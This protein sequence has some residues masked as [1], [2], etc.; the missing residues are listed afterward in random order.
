[1]TGGDGM[2]LVAA[3]RR[4]VDEQRW[5]PP[6]VPGHA[7]VKR[8]PGRRRVPLPWPGPNGVPDA[9]GGLGQVGRA[10]LG[11]AA[12][13]FRFLAST[14][15]ARGAGPVAV[16]DFRDL[17]RG[18]PSGGAYHPGELYLRW[19][20]SADLPA[21]VYHHDPLHHALTEVA[22][23]ELPAPASYLLACRVWKN[24]QK[25]G[26][27]GYR[28]GCIDLGALA[29]HLLATA[30]GSAISFFFDQEEAD[31][32]AALAPE[33]ETVYALVGPPGRQPA[34]RC[35]DAAGG[36]GPSLDRTL[37]ARV[38]AQTRALHAAAG[39]PP[40][41]VSAPVAPPAPADRMDPGI[42]LSRRSA[43]AF[44]PGGL[45]AERLMDVLAR[46][47]T[48]V[49]SDVPAAVAESGRLSLYCV[50]VGVAGLAPGAYRYD[51][52]RHRLSRCGPGDA[53][54][55]LPAAVFG[56]V[57]PSL[58]GAAS[59]FV[60]GRYESGVRVTGARW[61]RVLNMLAGVVVHRLYLS[62][63]VAGLGARACLGYYVGAVD[64]MLGL[65]GGDTALVHVA[66]GRPAPWP[67][68]VELALF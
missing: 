9:G 43:A 59:V 27:F 2:A 58:L 15:L 68:Q 1:M 12:V 26:D 56:L 4:L 60:V 34:P 29:G 44:R 19:P 67:G 14:L 8:Y 48:G 3:Y 49:P 57:H 21:G 23:C 37:A 11:C 36:G 50:A 41:G 62:A 22:R 16:P 6:A 28:L 53:A 52:R 38:A 13:R 45:P 65:S 30:P 66:I 33:V 20:G 55:R 46:T 24:S 18:V 39:A 63:G 5:R 25:Y 61:Y 35:G 40:C 31:R 47:A 64:A 17:P 10:L 42:L 32:S 51:E 7:G 54:A